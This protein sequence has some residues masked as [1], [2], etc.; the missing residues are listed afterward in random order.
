[1]PMNAKYGISAINWANEGDRTLGDHYEGEEILSQMA[2]LGFQGTE[3]SRKFP[4]DV[5]SLRRLLDRYGM[6][7]TSQWRSVFFHERGKHE[8]E[9]AAFKQH[10]DFLKAMGC[11]FVVTCESSNVTKRDGS[12]AEVIPLSEEQWTN[13]VDG[14]HEA[15]RYCRDL[16]MTLVYHFHGDTVVEGPREIERLMAS[17]D[18]ALVS[19]LY[20]T[21]H[22][23]FGNSDPLE[24]LQKFANR[25][26]Y[27]H[28]KDVR[29]EVL[30]WMRE[31]KAS[32][33]DAVRKGV[34]TVPGDGCID[35]KPIFAELDRS[36]YDGWIIIEA[37]QDPLVAD[38]LLYG[39]KCKRYLQSL[40]APL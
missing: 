32:F 4:S 1:M 2:S 29:P 11:R 13:V 28:L 3:H 14:L 7:L 17:T 31:Q 39:E 34:F 33:S 8:Q 19:L 37:E 24:L 15:G 27:I 22:A 20:D 6:V 10:A 21:G 5:D 40:G 16:G 18:P 12:P 30:V 35:F 23:Y 36:G 9:L 26:P 25:I 38:P